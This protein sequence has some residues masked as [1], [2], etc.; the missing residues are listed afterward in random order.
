[1]THK[2]TIL[3]LG[4]VLV[5]LHF[6]RFFTRCAEVG[7]RSYDEIRERFSNTE[8]K[9]Q[10]ERGEITEK[11]LF[12][13]MVDWMSWP[14]E[15][16]DELIYFWCDIFSETKGA[17]EAVQLFKSRG[18]VW[19]LSDTVQS[20]VDFIRERFP[21]ALDVDRVITSYERGICK[22]EPGGF[23]SII[24]ESNLPPEQ[25]LFFDDLQ[26]NIDAARKVGID[27]RLFTGWN[28]ISSFPHSMG[29]IQRG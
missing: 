1:M 18:P 11:E 28:S 27:A 16:K 2:L 10:V 8:Y 14:P 9:D 23:E 26:I 19:V 17:P 21:Y 13:W 24:R 12:A 25:I 15:R 7:S 22:R 5:D 4:N 29:E 20:H 6:D 3:D